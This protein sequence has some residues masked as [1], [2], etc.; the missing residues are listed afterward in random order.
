MPVNFTF[1]GY[2]I[3]PESKIRTFKVPIDQQSHKLT[4]STRD[5]VIHAIMVSSKEPFMVEVELTDIHKNDDLK[6]TGVFDNENNTMN[7]FPPIGKFDDGKVIITPKPVSGGTGKLIVN[8]QYSEVL[9]E[10]TS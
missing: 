2:V 7:F 8:I 3:I 6:F 5:I 4:V 9:G 1:E 10:V